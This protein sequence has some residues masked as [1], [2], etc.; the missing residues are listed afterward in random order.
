M[1]GDKMLQR[2]IIGIT[3]LIWLGFLYL[4]F[5]H[6][7]SAGISHADDAYM[8]IGA[9][10]LARG[11]GYSSS[12]PPDGSYGLAWF[13]AG[14]TTGPVL[15]FPTA[16]MIKLSGNAPW[17]PGVTAAIVNTFLL[18]LLAWLVV[19]AAGT[20]GIPFLSVWLLMMY[21]LSAGSFFEHWN[22]MLGEVP[23]ALS[24]LIGLLIYIQA[25][26]KRSSIYL[27]S[28]AFGLAFMSKMVSVLGFIPLVA[29]WLIQLVADKA[30]RQRRA[31]ELFSGLGF[32]LLP[33]LVFDAYKLSVLGFDAYLK[34]YSDFF[35]AFSQW[36]QVSSTGQP[37]ASVFSF[38]TIISRFRSVCE[39]LGISPLA[40]MLSFL[41]LLII[42]FRLSAGSRFRN[43]MFLLTAGTLVHF[44]W[45]LLLSSGRVRYFLI[46]LIFYFT[47]IAVLLLLET[48][49]ILKVVAVIVLLLT[50]S[51]APDR[52]KG[53]VTFATRTHFKYSAQVKNMMKTAGF[54]KSRTDLRPFVYSW[55][56]N[57]ADLDYTLPTVVNFKRIDYLTPADF[58]RELLLVRNKKWEIPYLNNLYAE[59]A[60]LFNEVVFEAGPYQV[61]RFRPVGAVK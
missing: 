13:P 26:E 37:G 7:F 22:S 58:T 54:L 33:F 25:P 35:N 15:V 60:D 47:A 52:L 8:A 12:L 18:I 5:A 24:G 44:S 1:T 45:W 40:M 59:K 61:L 27:A 57:A 42:S 16:L 50:F 38:E 3:V 51:K 55:W 19:R 2:V 10:N 20:D 21:N 6:A 41:A 14:Y 31:F 30:D 36:H 46:G 56:A 53:P 39:V 9:K 49:R 32:F 48:P 23:A 11:Y 4:N 43:L 17:V 29:W 28:L 34:N